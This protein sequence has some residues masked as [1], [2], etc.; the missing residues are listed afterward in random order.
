MAE[1]V[2]GKESDRK[3]TPGTG[4]GVMRLGGWTGSD[5][6]EMLGRAP[7][8]G[9]LGSGCW[10]PGTGLGQALQTHRLRARVPEVGD[11]V[12]VHPRHSSKRSCP[13][14][15]PTCAVTLGAVPSHSHQGEVES[16]VDCCFLQL[17]ARG[18][19]TGQLPAREPEVVEAS[20][21]E[22]GKSYGSPSSR[23]GLGA[24]GRGRARSTDF[25]P[26]GE[27]LGKAQ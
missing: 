9:K 18:S 25:S 22:P 20:E 3:K 4:R 24:V 2:A 10:T 16:L 21:V 19:H 11:L 13:G 17:P 15:A 6:R 23:L 26:P 7:E 5:L 12:W 8:S 27:N 14:S 1:V